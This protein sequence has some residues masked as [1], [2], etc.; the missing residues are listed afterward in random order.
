MARAHWC[1][2]V[3]KSVRAAAAAG[4]GRSRRQAGHR[5]RC[6]PYLEQLETR[7]APAV[8]LTVNTVADSGPGSLRAEIPAAHSGDTIVFDPSLKGQTITLQS[9]ELLTALEHEVGHLLGY[10]HADGDL[11]DA[12]LAAGTRMPI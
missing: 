12:T 11:R 5:P 2:V 10:D 4:R 8:T 6:R 7:L 9:G 1:Q 3:R